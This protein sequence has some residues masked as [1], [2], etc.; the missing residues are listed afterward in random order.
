MD[1]DLI[2]ARIKN[3]TDAI[4]TIKKDSNWLHA[5]KIENIDDLLSID[6]ANAGNLATILVRYKG[7]VHTI[8]DNNSDLQA[9]LSEERRLKLESKNEIKTDAVKK[10]FSLILRLSTAFGTIIVSIIAYNY[11]V[12]NGYKMP[13]LLKLTPS[14]TSPAAVVSTMPGANQQISQPTTIDENV[15]K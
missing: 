5:K 14:A 10:L 4:S 12:D 11:A 6:E 3:N 8:I 2:E 13:A 9:I 7:L 1:R 15:G